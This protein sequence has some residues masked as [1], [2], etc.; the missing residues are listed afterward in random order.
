MS[1]RLSVQSE[2]DKTR[3]V[4][5]DKGSVRLTNRDMTSLRWIGEQ[6][7]VRFDQLARLLGRSA[8]RTLTESTTRAAVNRWNRGGFAKSRKVTVGEPGFVWLTTRGL[9]DVGLSFK[10]W[11]P[12]ASTVNHLYWTNQVRLHAE[13]RHP[14]LVWRAERYMRA[15]RPTQTIS[16]CSSHIADGELRSEDAVVGVEVELTSKSAPRRESIMRLLAGEYMTVWYFAPP[17]VLPTLERTASQL[18][19]RVQE[20][21]RVYPLERV[22]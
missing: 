8:G 4:R 3:R 15:G 20:R 5:A 11:E 7:A 12:S 16:D 21:I 1:K 6:Y 22:A 14:D 13:E 17:N 18:D 10:A 19:A 9:R 2:V